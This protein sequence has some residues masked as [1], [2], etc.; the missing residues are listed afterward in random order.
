MPSSRLLAGALAAGLLLSGCLPDLFNRDPEPSESSSAVTTTSGPTASA[1]GVP[2]DAGDRK[3]PWPAFVYEGMDSPDRPAVEVP[4]VAPPGFVSAP[5]G[6]G[7]QRYLGQQLTWQPC[8]D[9]SS[10][11]CTT[12][13]APLDWEDPDGQAITIAMRRAGEAGEHGHLFINPG[14]PGGSAQDYANGFDASGV[15]GYAIVGLDS[16]GS[17]ESTP[18]VCGTGAQTDDYYNVD[19]TPDDQAERDALIAAQQAF[20]AECRANSGRLLDHISSIETI[21]DYDLARQLLGDEKLNFYGVSYGTYLG[22][23]YAELYPQ[24]VGRM[25][26]DSAVNP[27]PDD[28]VIQ[29]MG[30][31]L[32]LRNFAKWCAAQ[33][34][35][36]LGGSEQ[37]VIDRVVALLNE[38]DAKPLPGD[39]TRQLTQSLAITGVVLYFYFGS[40]AYSALS[41]VLTYT[42][43]TRDGQYLLQ[44]A[45]LLNER[46]PDGTYGGLTYAFPAIRC[47]DSADEGIDRAFDAW[48]GDDSQKAPIFGPLFGPDLVCPL[49]TAE[50]APQIDFTGAGAPPILIIQN[51]GDSATPYRNAELLNGEL[52]SSIL[53][54]RDAPGHGAY[55]SGSSCLDTVVDDY[56]NQGVV[57]E[58]G[59]RCTDG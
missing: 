12:F 51:T 10:L 29:A 55:M 9:D 52:E 37:E 35:C 32:S 8:A 47:L 17:G 24:N 41:D 49:W 58:P 30:F 6:E 2:N 26:L 3:M 59:V 14:G 34:E 13:A 48:T 18:V 16:R 53:V 57:P 27:T 38:L 43:E 1:T 28:E 4:D 46:Y 20:N 22:A 7:Y 21:Y 39:G 33:S 45:D 54:V 56:F 19:S 31:D 44:S 36:T 40:E 11:Q 25:V 23:V 15:P 5:P 42:I 50:P